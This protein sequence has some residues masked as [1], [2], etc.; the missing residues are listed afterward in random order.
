MVIGEKFFVTQTNDIY[1]NYRSYLGKTIVYEGLF[2]ES[3]DIWGRTSRFVIRYG[4]GCCGYD[5]NAGFEVVWDGEWPNP[6]DWVAVEGVLGVYEG[7]GTYGWPHL[8]LYVTSMEV[9]S[10]RGQLYVVR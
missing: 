8:Y 6:E 10:K 4:P 7:S 3:R 2:T 1:I 5:Q 9:Q